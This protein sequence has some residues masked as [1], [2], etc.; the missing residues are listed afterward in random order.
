MRTVSLLVFVAAFI[1]ADASAGEPIVRPRLSY[2]LVNTVLVHPEAFPGD[3][4]PNLGVVFSESHL[5]FRV[6]LSA[7]P[8]TRVEVQTGPSKLLL[9]DPWWRKLSITLEPLDRPEFPSA[10]PL[11]FGSE[12]FEVVDSWF[13]TP[14]GMS[15]RSIE[16][17]KSTALAALEIAR[18]EI[19]IPPVA[20]GDYTVRFTLSELAT[21]ASGPLCTSP[22]TVSIREGT[23][24]GAL[25]RMY[26]SERRKSAT[27]FEEFRDIQM[28]LI[29][30]DPDAWGLWEE[31][32]NVSLADRPPT[33]TLSYYERASEL[34][35]R[36][37]AA[38][39]NATSLDQRGHLTPLFKQLY[40]LYAQEHQRL[41]LVPTS[42][43]GKATFQWVDRKT[44]K[45]LGYVDPSR[46]ALPNVVES[47]K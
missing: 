15:G 8:D 29:K 5:K 34:F 38:N 22:K 33:E 31:L 46:P 39:P 4:T 30:L 7:D 32:G 26:L 6:E 42:R 43:D 3:F 24:N 17:E 20:P 47:P 23:E 10:R 37:A 28:K 27:S 41:K 2:R 18:A 12:E 36:F 16:R 35:D 19:R 44:G 11:T 45:L 14:D 1:T 40:P 9:G 25:E 13:F 21:N